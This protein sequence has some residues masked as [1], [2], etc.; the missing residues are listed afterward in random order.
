[1]V[2]ARRLRDVG[3]DEA[4]DPD[5]DPEDL[6]EDEQ[7]DEDEDEDEA[8]PSDVGLTPEEDVPLEATDADWLDQQREAPLDEDDRDLRP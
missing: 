6:D 5:V 1:V 3:K 7:L 8:E 4:M 2:D